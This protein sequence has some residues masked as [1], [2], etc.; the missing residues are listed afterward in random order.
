[1]LMK[2]EKIF[3]KGDKMHFSFF[4]P[5]G[6][7]VR[8]RGEVVRDIRQATTTHGCRYGV[9]FTEIDPKNKSAI[10]MYVQKK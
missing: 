3:A 8:I 7:R 1:M 2:T 6:I 9:H 10:E 4:L 5:G